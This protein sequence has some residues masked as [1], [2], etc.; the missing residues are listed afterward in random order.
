MRDASL[1]YRKI[2]KEVGVSHATVRYNLD[3][4][5]RGQRREYRN[6]NKDRIATQRAGHYIDNRDEI[7]ARHARYYADH[8]EK[9]QAHN[10]AYYTAHKSE[11]SVQ[12]SGYRRAHLPECAA[13]DAVRKALIAGTMI[14]ITAAQKVQIDKIYRRAKE[15]PKARC[16]LCDKLIP[17]GERHVDHIVPVSKGGPTR[18]SNLAIACSACNLSKSN[19]M[20]Y[21]VGVLI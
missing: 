13:Q 14:G 15:D 18:P 1:S 7:L 6:D 11:I 4:S 8:R 21:E 5:I 12:K 19:K 10:K 20:P 3:P 9:A 2:G 16:Y 17:L